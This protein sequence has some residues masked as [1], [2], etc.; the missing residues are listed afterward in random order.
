MSTELNTTEKN[1]VAAQARN[2]RRPQYDVTEQDDS[3]EVTVSVPGVN[4]EGV[5]ISVHED[6][7]TVTAS[8]HTVTPES[9]RPLRRELPEGDY[10]LSLRLNV[11]INEDKIAAQVVDGLLTL[12]LPKADEVKPRRIKVS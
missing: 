4:K 10:R 7:L 12:T 11:R 6:T 3:F 9:W 2:W 8:R 1:P 5:D